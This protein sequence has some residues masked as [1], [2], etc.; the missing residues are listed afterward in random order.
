M[1]RPVGRAGAGRMLFPA[2]GQSATVCNLYSISSVLGL[3]APAALLRFRPASLQGRSGRK[4]GKSGL[5]NAALFFRSQPKFVL[6]IAIF[7][8]G[9]WW[10]YCLIRRPLHNLLLRNLNDAATS[11]RALNEF[12]VI[13]GG[14][15]ANLLL[16]PSPN[17]ISFSS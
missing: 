6:Y 2:E 15:F 17:T 14:F 1:M 7:Y 8:H 4:K 3:F 5:E 12:H 9:L 16:L 13:L 11:L 10:S